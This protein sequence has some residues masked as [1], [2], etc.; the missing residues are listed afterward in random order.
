MANKAFKHIFLVEPQF[1]HTWSTQH[2]RTLKVSLDDSITSRCKNVQRFLSINVQKLRLKW[3][4]CICNKTSK[5]V[6][7][8]MVFGVNYLHPSRNHPM[9]WFLENV[10]FLWL[11]GDFL[12][13]IVVP[14]L[15]KESTW[16]QMFSSKG[17]PI[18]LMKVR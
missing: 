11:T 7:R 8:E 18:G 5:T 1:W 10:Q 17:L 14:L 2:E 12:H 6:A 15:I 4:I 9:V 13:I 16:E 3:E